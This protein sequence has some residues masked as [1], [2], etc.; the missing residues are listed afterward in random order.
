MKL[1]NEAPEDDGRYALMSTTP[2]TQI[3]TLTNV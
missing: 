2:N 1:A 3:K